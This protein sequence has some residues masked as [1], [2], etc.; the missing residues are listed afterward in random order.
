MWSK[1]HKGKFFKFLEA[2]YFYELDNLESFAKIFFF[3][4]FSPG[5]TRSCHRCTS[6]EVEK[7]YTFGFLLLFSMVI[8]YFLTKN[9]RY[10]YCPSRDILKHYFFDRF[11]W[12]FYQTKIFRPS[13]VCAHYGS[14]TSRQISETSFLLTGFR[15]TL[16][17]HGCTDGRTNKSQK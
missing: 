15:E 11:S 10:L 12:L 8:L 4:L 3:N 1:G 5:D 7:E 16:L 6:P 9:E 17:T 13:S 14:V 2:Y